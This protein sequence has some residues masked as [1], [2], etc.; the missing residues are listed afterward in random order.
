MQLL[1][2]DTVSAK[3]FSISFEMFSST[4]VRWWRIFL[5]VCVAAFCL[6]KILYFIFYLN[7]IVSN[8]Y[9]NK[10]ISAYDMLKKFSQ[11]WYM[12]EI[13]LFL[14]QFGASVCLVF[15]LIKKCRSLRFIRR[16]GTRFMGTEANN[17]DLWSDWTTSFVL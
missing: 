1:W 17:L 10:Y 4:Y 11:R 13:Y 14:K 12:L 3:Y 5:M 6:N 9:I 15:M 8:F 16:W 7:R 2:K